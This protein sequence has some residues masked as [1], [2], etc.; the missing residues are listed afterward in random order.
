ME[1]L[2]TIL[3][4]WGLYKLF[5]SS[6]PEEQ[7][8]TK[9]TN[10]SRKSNLNRTQV[11]K[12][13]SS[14]K[15]IPY[16]DKKNRPS[17]NQRTYAGPQ[18][19][20]PGEKSNL[21]GYGSFTGVQQYDGPY[22][23]IDL[24]TS[25]FN[26]PENKILEIAILKIDKNGEELERFTTLVNP[27]DN[28][29][30]RVDIHQIEIDMLIDAP[31]FEDISG[32]VLEMIENSIVVA[33]N[34]RFEENFLFHE[35]TEAGH[36]LPIIPALDTLWLARQTKDLPNYKLET[37]VHGFN[38]K[39]YNQHTALGDVLAVSKILPSM[40][41]LSGPIFYPIRFAKLPQISTPFKPLP[42]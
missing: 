11:N 14:S 29:V 40:L 35:M 38:E 36:D 17:R 8:I 7:P 19:A 9:K 26:P 25:G 33:H 5:F 2:I 27:E 22:S 21:F 13:V 16:S 12:S 20:Q 31:T 30:G 39:F 6:K 1:G 23:I 42:R 24:E 18:F 3:V 15:K 4:I 41:A 37:V 34:A 28:E 32:R 10:T